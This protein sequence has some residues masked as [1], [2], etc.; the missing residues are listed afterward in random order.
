M[1]R[2][3]KSKGKK[4]PQQQPPSLS[5]AVDGLIGIAIGAAIVIWFFSGM[6]RALMSWLP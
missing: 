3:S 6:W 4:Q 2:R 5:R 1:R